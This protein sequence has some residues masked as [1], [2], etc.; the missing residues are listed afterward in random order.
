MLED[1]A[2]D[3]EPVTLHPVLSSWK[4]YMDDLAHEL[5]YLRAERLDRPH[6]RTRHGGRD[7]R[8]AARHLLGL[9]SPL[10]AEKEYMKISWELAEALEAG[11]LFDET[12][13]I[14]YLVKL[15]ILIRYGFFQQEAGTEEFS[16][17]FSHI[18]TRIEQI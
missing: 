9:K 11:H 17:V 2:R 13:L 3:R 14:L 18:Q 6:E 5:S 8:E 1:L 16:S 10:E 12:T 7:V 15:K 4:E